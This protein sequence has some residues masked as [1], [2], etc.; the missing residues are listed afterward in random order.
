MERISLDRTALR[1]LDEY[2]EYTRI[3]GEDDG[4]T[5]FTPQQYEEYKRRVVPGRLHNR[6]YVS[7][8]VPGG[9][10]CKLIGPETPCFCTHRYKQH[11]T[12]LE[13][14]PAQRPL[15]LACRVRGCSC[16]RYQ[17]VPHTGSRP[18]RC[19][20]KHLPEEHQAS[21]GHHCSRCLCRGFHSPSACGCGR[22]YSAHRTLVESGEERQAR[23]APVGRAVPY[24]AMGGLTG[25]SFAHGRVPQTGPERSRSH[26]V[27]T[28]ESSSTTSRI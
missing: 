10:D 13:Q 17:Y 21:G 22:P 8:G 14:L 25:F 27:Y 1:A 5:L 7:Y 4:G 9:P 18:V 20:C 2:C 23:G 6:L 28:G 11:Q 19:S 15:E 12:E 24:Q 16:S 26:P 3:V